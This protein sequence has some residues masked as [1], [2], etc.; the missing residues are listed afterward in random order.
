MKAEDFATYKKALGLLAE[1]LPRPSVGLVASGFGASSGQRFLGIS[2]TDRDEQTDGSDNDGSI[3]VG[4]GFG[5]P[6]TS[7]GTEVS[8]GITSVSTSLWGD[9]NFADEGNINVK[10]HREISLPQPFGR[11]SVAFGVSNLA[12]W[13]APKDNPMNFYTALSAS[14]A[15]GKYAQYGALYTLG[16]GTAVSDAETSGDLFGGIGVGRS[17][18]SMS[19]SFIGSNLHLTGN[20]Y[21]SFVKNAVVSY[22]RSDF[23]NNSGLERNIISLGLSF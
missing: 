5:D 3:I 14:Q 20:W 15:L 10:F 19:M 22:T 16:Y 6:V 21:P 2:Y 17:S 13:G 11:S 9:G 8:I 4:M 23:T 12:G 1:T 7:I 18:Y